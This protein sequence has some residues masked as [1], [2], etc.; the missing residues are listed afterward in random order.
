MATTTLNG[1]GSQ[2]NTG[3]ESIVIKLALDG[4]EGGRSLNVT[5][6]GPAVIQAGHV[7]IQDTVSKD[8]KPMPLATNDTVYGTLPTDHVY[9][10]VL[11]S[12]VLKATPMA[13]ILTNGTANPEATPFS[14]TTILAAFKTAVPFIAWRAD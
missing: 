5:G 9:V 2:V 6:F 14:M 8:Y 3:K 1:A 4:I 10:G 11:R 12:S 13:G 7:I